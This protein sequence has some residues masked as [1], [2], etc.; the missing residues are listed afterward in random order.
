MG[1]IFLISVNEPLT[2]QNYSLSLEI[3]DSLERYRIIAVVIATDL[4]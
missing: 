3:D 4:I 2:S 1:S